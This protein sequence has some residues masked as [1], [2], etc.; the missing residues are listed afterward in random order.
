MITGRVQGVWF[1]YETQKAAIGMGVCGYVENMPDG[2]V[3]AVAE[4]DEDQLGIFVAFCRKG[5]PL[6]RV[7]NIDAAWSE[8]GGEFDGFSIRH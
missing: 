8:A 3:H 6:A 4:G 2:S 5:P 1:R 7:E